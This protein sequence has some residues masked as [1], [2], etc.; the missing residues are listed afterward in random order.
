MWGSEDVIS[1]D[2]CT[3][4]V[5]WRGAPGDVDAAVAAAR[6]ALP[7]W[8]GAPLEARVAA[9]R[10]F[11]EVVRGRAEELARLIATETGKPLWETRTEA[12]SVIAKVDISITAQAERAAAL[13]P[14]KGE[15]DQRPA[16]G[17]PYQR[18]NPIAPKLPVVPVSAPGGLRLSI[19]PV[20]T[21]RR[22]T[23]PR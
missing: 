15:Q 6:A 17:Q 18:M 21:R 13:W 4:A 11:Q 2:P 12:A 16:Q 22:E 7:G 3:G 9:V 1:T 8:A 10:R 14:N 5:I 19:T 23:A 20:N